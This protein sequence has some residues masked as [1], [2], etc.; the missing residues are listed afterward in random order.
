MEQ[1][2]IIIPCYNEADRIGETI[3]EVTEDIKEVTEEKVGCNY[4]IIIV[5]DGSNDYSG[6]VFLRL[7]LQYPKTLTILRYQPNRGKGYAVR[8]G[9]NH[10]KTKRCVIIDADHSI[11]IRS[12][13]KLHRN[14]IWRS[15]I[16]KGERDYQIPQPWH[17]MIAGKVW[18]TIVNVLFRLNMDT[19]APFTILKM[20]KWFY[21]QLEIDGFAYDVEIL[22]LARQYGYKIASVPVE[23][24]HRK[25]SKVTLRKSMRM[26]WDLLR[27]K[28][29]QLFFRK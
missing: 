4:R 24:Y 8:Y 22:A 7:M 5:D 29:N 12:L 16:I 15:D 23:F 1:T 17:R 3:K 10:A 19:Q 6:D 13:R 28:K 20:P 14:K 9:L 18:K 27:I 11:P 26:A 21:Q 25:G 2:T